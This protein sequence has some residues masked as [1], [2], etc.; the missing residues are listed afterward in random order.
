MIANSTSV[1]HIF[2]SICYKFDKMFSKRA[3]IHWYAGSGMDEAE[4]FEARENLAAL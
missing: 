2:N 3:F 4:F 1:E